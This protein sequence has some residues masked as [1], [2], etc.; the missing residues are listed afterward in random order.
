MTSILINHDYGNDDDDEDDEDDDIGNYNAKDKGNYNDGHD[1][2]G[3][4][5]LVMVVTLITPG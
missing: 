2:D 3:D 1:F 5:G 4:I